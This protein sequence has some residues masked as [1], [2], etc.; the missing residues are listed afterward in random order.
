M[1]AHRHQQ[2]TLRNFTNLNCQLL[3][4]HVDLKLLVAWTILCLDL[5]Q[6]AKW[7]II[8]HKPEFK[9]SVSDGKTNKILT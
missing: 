5:V 4:G 1:F 9:S 7:S 3:T 2:E 6:S 8:D